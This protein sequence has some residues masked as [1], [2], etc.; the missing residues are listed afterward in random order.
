MK[1]SKFIA[2][3]LLMSAMM[4]SVGVNTNAVGLIAP[5]QAASG[6]DSHFISEFKN[7]AFDTSQRNFIRFTSFLFYRCLFH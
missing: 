1:A 2:M 3:V 5:A 7:G 6:I 4:A